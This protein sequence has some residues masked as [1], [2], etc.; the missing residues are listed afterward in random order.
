LRARLTGVDFCYHLAALR[1]TACAED[2]RTAAE[3]MFMG[4]FNVLEACIQNRVKKVVAAS[5]A[6]IYGCADTFPTAET[7]HPYNNRTFYGAAKLANEMMLRSFYD[8]HRLPYCALR[9]FNVYGPGMDA[10]GKYTEVLIRW[11]RLAKAGKPPLIFGD[12]SQTMD[13]V[14]V[15]DAARALLLVLKSDHSDEVFNVASG[16]ETSLTELCRI[17]LRVMGSPL[18][19]RCQPM[20]SDRQKVEVPRRLADTGKARQKLGFTAHVSLE[21]G[22]RRLVEWLDGMKD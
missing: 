12:G 6:S 17:L 8:M 1:I 21:E 5:S 14:Y 16:T 4:T 9:F 19:P 20:P 15:E 13:F 10:F 7:H 22:L 11:Y 18:E 3:V 2:P